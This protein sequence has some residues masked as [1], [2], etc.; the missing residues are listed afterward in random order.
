MSLHP[1]LSEPELN[2]AKRKLRSQFF[3]ESGYGPEDVLAL[4]YETGIFLTRNGG[5]YQLKD[6][7][8]IRLEG[9]ALEVEE[10]M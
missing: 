4:N 5:K 10:R 7:K 2:E 6:G 3:N 8:F 9:P 1:L